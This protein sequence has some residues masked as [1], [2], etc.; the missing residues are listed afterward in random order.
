[1]K[2]EVE[3]TLRNKQAQEQTAFAVA[4]SADTGTI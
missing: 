4:R 1:L 2:D 3:N